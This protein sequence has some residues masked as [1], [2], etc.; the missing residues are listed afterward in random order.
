MEP[1]SSLEEP[2]GFEFAPKGLVKPGPDISAGK[3][4][5]NVLLY[6]LESPKSGDTLYLA[7]SK[8]DA[9]KAMIFFV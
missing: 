7:P 4:S 8:Q 6:W 9:D 5:R 3:L 1:V 2:N